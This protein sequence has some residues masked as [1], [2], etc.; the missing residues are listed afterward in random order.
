MNLKPERILMK[1]FAGS[2]FRVIWGYVFQR[3]GNSSEDI[4]S[5]QVWSYLNLRVSN[6][7]KFFWRN[8]LSFS[9]KLG[10]LTSFKQKR[11]LVKTFLHS[12]FE[13]IYVYEFQ[14]KPICYED[15]CWVSVWSYLS[16]GVSNKTKFLWRHLLSLGLKLSMFTNFKQQRILIKTFVESQLEDMLIH[17]FQARA[18]SYEDICWGSVWSYVSLWVSNQSEFSWRHLLS[19]GLKFSLFM[20]FKQN[21]ILIRTFVECQSEVL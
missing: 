6:N 14:G 15:I 3:T 1:T 18:N 7:S 11:I 19:L 9:L 20:S 13:V 8:L 10:N 5:L 16:L 21:R 17:W 4:C 12:Q 2:K